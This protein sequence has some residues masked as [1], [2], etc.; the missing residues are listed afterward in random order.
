M[1]ANAD[2]KNGDLNMKRLFVLII[3]LVIIT[4]A[5]SGCNGAQAPKKDIIDET[6]Q[7]LVL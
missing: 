4:G 7:T 3:V 1:I 6:S 2:N 5:T